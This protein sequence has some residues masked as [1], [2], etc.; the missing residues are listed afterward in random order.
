MR[1]PIS[2][3]TN[4]PPTLHRFDRSKIAISGYPSCV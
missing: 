2:D 4:L 3:Y 1:L